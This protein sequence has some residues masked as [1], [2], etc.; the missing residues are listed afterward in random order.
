MTWVL[1]SAQLGKAPALQASTLHPVLQSPVLSAA[2]LT[3]WSLARD[4]GFPRGVC[5]K[6]LQSSWTLCDSMYPS[7]GSTVHG[8]LQARIL[9]WV[10]MPSSRGSSRPETEPM[11]LTSTALAGEFFTVSAT[12]KSAEAFARSQTKIMAS[13][14]I[15][16][17]EIDG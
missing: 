1:S 9:E 7:P 16:S 12:L 8:I 13:G 10:T 17:W 5:A 14:P 4:S 2:P 6:S 11:V 15:T 3:T